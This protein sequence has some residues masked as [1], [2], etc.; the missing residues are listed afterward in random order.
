M[1]NFFPGPDGL[2]WA[3]VLVVMTG[4]PL[5]GVILYLRR[6]LRQEVERHRQTS[7]ELGKLSRVVEQS[8]AAVVVT[9]AQG[10]IEYINPKFSEITGYSREMAVGQNPR[11]LNAGK[12]SFRHY[13]KL[14]ETIT[15]GATWSGEFLN[16]KKDGTL[17][18]S[19]AQI[20]G[21]RNAS[22]VIT[23]FVGVQ[24]DIT[25]RKKAMEN[26]QVSERRLALALRGGDLGYWDVDFRTATTIV[27][28]RWAEMLGYGLAEIKHRCRDIWKSSIHP[29]DQERVVQLGRDYRRGLIEHYEVEYRVVTRLQQTRWFLSKGSGVEY[30]AH[31]LPLRMVGTVMDITPQKRIEEALR[32]SEKESARKSELLKAALS[33]IQ[34]GIAAY[35]EQLRLIACNQKFKEIRGV[36]D[37]MAQPG[38]SFIELLRYDVARGEF[39]PG[40]PEAQVRKYTELARH[41]T[42]HSFER[43]RP[44]GTVIEVVGGPLP[45]GGFVSTYTDIT[46]RKLSEETLRR[47]KQEAETANRAK[48]DFLANMSHEIRTPMN[49][50]IGMAHLCLQAG[51]TPKQRNYLEKIHSAA[52][53]LLHIINDILDFSKVESGKLVMEEVPFRLQEVCNHISSMANVK[54]GEK[55]LRLVI[56]MEPGA[57]EIAVGDPLRLVQVLL[58][59]TN[60]AIKFTDHGQVDITLRRLASTA[61]THQL[62][63]LVQDTGIGLTQEQMDRLFQSFTQ[64]DSSTTR[65]Y[66]GTGL[67]LAICKRLVELMH[68]TIH[69]ASTPGQGSTFSFSAPFGQAPPGTICKPIFSP[70]APSL[71][72]EDKVRLRGA[73]I[74]LAEDNEINRELAKEL[75]EQAGMEVIEAVDGEEA[76]ARLHATNFDA[77]LLDLQMPKMD[78]FQ[79]TQT[80]R[81]DDAFRQ[82]PIIALT[83]NAMS[84][85]VERCLSIGMNDHIAKPIVPDIMYATLLRWVRPRLTTSPPVVASPPQ[86]TS[87]TPSELGASPPDL[88]RFDVQTGLYPKLST[89]LPDLPGFDVQAGLYRVGDNLGLY[90]RLLQKFRLNHGDM[91]DRIRQELDHNYMQTARELAHTLKGVAGNVGTTRLFERVSLLE[92]AIKR[93]E[94]DLIKPLMDQASSA[95]A[96]VLAAIASLEKQPTDPSS[97]GDCTS[98]ETCSAKTAMMPVMQDPCA[99][100]NLLD[101]MNQLLHLLSMDDTAATHHLVTLQPFLGTSPAWASLEKSVSQYDFTTA[102]ATLSE[103]IRDLENI[104]T[105]VPHERPASE[106]DHSGCR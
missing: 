73:R 40:D 39:G 97:T 75:L 8:P 27:N 102:V 14:W 33:S 99:M 2:G 5:A 35:D 92:T 78:G 91:L 104:T 95:M 17:Y 64:A 29:E 32:E 65:K 47:A 26:L 74:L 85:D 77:L 3:V 96:E 86:T 7:H 83:A 84:G 42:T 38:S 20:S 18:W 11:I 4:V 88:P 90:R 82:L 101:A 12:G 25:E 31:G 28:D 62:E 94:M 89:P 79:V 70:P 57:P 1:E 105:R 30:D 9:N 53:S 56:T 68:G 76:L 46:E 55:G 66:G 13:R 16:R 15:Q 49:V 106:T 37:E 44:N 60:N 81:L 34:Q 52:N 10:R 21:I 100:D 54:A 6:R 63:F 103:M 23:H 22:G 67:G 71:N 41:S 87:S 80:V 19:S 48:S 45:G 69:V 93:E 72:D 58:N 61:T 98:G 59:L 50:I 24:E 43:T 51:L 36:P